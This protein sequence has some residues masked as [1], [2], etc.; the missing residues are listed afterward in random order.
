MLDPLEQKSRIVSGRIWA[1]RKGEIGTMSR[2]RIALF[3]HQ[4]RL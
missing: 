3:L 2:F 4:V 1:V